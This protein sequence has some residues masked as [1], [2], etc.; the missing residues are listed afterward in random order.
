MDL[1]SNKKSE[2]DELIREQNISDVFVQEPSDEDQ[3][4]SGEVIRLT[5]ENSALQDDV[6]KKQSAIAR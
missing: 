3:T 1:T 5:D 4:L 6:A 2:L